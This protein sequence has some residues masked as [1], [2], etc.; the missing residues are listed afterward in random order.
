[1]CVWTNYDLFLGAKLVK[2]RY[3]YSAWRHK[4]G[5]QAIGVPGKSIECVVLGGEE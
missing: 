1:M 5:R 3:W 2:P 4:G